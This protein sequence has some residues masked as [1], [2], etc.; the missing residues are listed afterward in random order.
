MLR[1]NVYIIISE[2]KSTVTTIFRRFTICSSRA[3]TVVTVTF[4]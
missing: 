4:E 1:N 2:T 3:A